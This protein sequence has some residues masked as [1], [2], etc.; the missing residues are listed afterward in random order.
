[1]VFGIPPCGS[2]VT[3][4]TPVALLKGRELD[5]QIV[6]SSPVPSWF[7]CWGRW[8]EWPNAW[9][10]PTVNFHILMTPSS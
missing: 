7:E 4:W 10:S 1:M 6:F 5:G 3:G 2:L 8:H 9:D